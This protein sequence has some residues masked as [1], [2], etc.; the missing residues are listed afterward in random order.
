[1]RLSRRPSRQR[2]E[3]RSHYSP[4]RS[5]LVSVGE[6]LE[7]RILLFRNVLNFGDGIHEAITSQALQFLRE[8]VLAEINLRHQVQDTAGAANSAN[9]FDGSEFEASAAKINEYLSAAIAEADPEDFD[10][11]DLEEQWGDML[12]TVQDFYAHSNWV[13]LGMSSLIDSG[14]GAWNAM[15]PYSLHSGAMLVEG[16]D[17]T[18]TVPGFGT[19]TLRR[20]AGVG[21]V[22]AGGFQGF[23]IVVDFGGG[24]TFPGVISGTFGPDNSPDNVSIGHDDPTFGTDRGLNKDSTSRHLH[25][26]A[27]VLAV[28]QTRHEFARLGALLEAEYG[29]EAVCKLLEVWVK[30]DEVSQAEA[31]ALLGI[32]HGPLD[33]VFVIDT[34]GSMGDDIAAVKASANEII[35]AIAEE[36]PC[37]RVSIVLYK[38]SGDTYVTKTWLGFTDDKD[39][40]LAA[41][42]SI[43]VGGGGDFPEAV[44]AA[45]DHAIL[46]LDGMGEWR[47]PSVEKS[48]ILMGDAP[49][50]DPDVATG[51]TLASVT[52]NALRAGLFPVSLAGASGLATGNLTPPAGDPVDIFTIVIGSNTAATEAFQ[53]IAAANRGRMF[54]AATA[55]DVVDAVLDAI[56]EVTGDS[57]ITGQKWNDLDGD[58]LRDA[59]EPGLD[60]WIVNVIDASGDIVGS[61][62]TAS[63]DLD[64]NGIIDPF[65]ESGI[66]TVAVSAGSYTVVEVVSSGWVQTAPSSPVDVVANELDEDFDF[67]TTGN[68]FRDWGGL[69][70]RWIYSD[71]GWHYITPAGG[72]FRWWGGHGENLNSSLVARLSPDYHAD[73]DLLASAPAPVEHVV[74][75]ASGEVVTGIDFGNR[76][77]STIGGQKWEDVNRDGDRDSGDRALN[78]WV[79]ELLDGTSGDV[80]AATTTQSLDLNLDGRIDPDTEVG[81]YLFEGVVPGT[82]D[83]REVMK[84][85]WVASTP[86]TDLLQQATD[87]DA[88]RDF[89]D[90]AATFPNWGGLNEKWIQGADGW[91]FI[92]PDGQVKKW[93]NSPRTAL[94]GTLVA[95]LSPW[96]HA[97]THRLTSPVDPASNLIDISTTTEISDRDFGNYRT[98]GTAGLLVSGNSGPGLVPGNVT[99]TQGKTELTIKGDRYDNQVAVFVNWE[100]NLTVV[101]LQGTK[102]NGRSEPLILR[103][104]T[105]YLSGKLKADMGDGRDLVALQGFTI[106]GDT[107]IEGGHG[108]DAFVS[109]D[110][111]FGRNLDILGGWGAI[112]VSLTDTTIANNLSVNGSEAIDTVS[113]NQVT[114]SNFTHLDMG[115]KSDLLLVRNSDFHDDARIR[116]GS[117]DDRL[118]GSGRAD[119]R[120]LLSVDGNPG[121]DSWNAASFLYGRRSTSSMESFVLADIDQVIDDVLTAFAVYGLDESLIK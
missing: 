45:L 69:D 93:N 107:R 105:T 20:V 85:G 53:A 71:A 6:S 66:Y 49:P 111:N 9:H 87:L 67:R 95:T 121:K 17:E 5:S 90:S 63:V 75:V 65:T 118:A 97:Q 61:A 115:A 14:T 110:M 43:S 80:I 76:G 98:N 54:T 30:P 10:Q 82:Y 40:A 36:S 62:T 35:N 116:L 120:R 25:D 86:S 31:A 21:D 27:R 48:I 94:T 41:I 56:G 37:F 119:F 102:V 28:Q 23:G 74:T 96:F 44:F 117:G 22:L 106:S 89:R 55:D 33:L 84:P 38:D 1:M 73:L 108:A 64:G 59:D 7:H 34:T 16:E 26:E 70:E 58:G 109:I 81:V 39:A 68:D 112:D 103:T 47:G 101:G 42:S 72:L 114:V 24:V 52:E 15:T 3:M 83:V 104:G 32:D 79:I 92:T 57:S 77:A 2:R 4:E 12:H 46:N 19:A 13:N 11:E 29:H 51:A 99:V 60:G 50:H 100:G 8:E 88:A 18:P 91:Y 113:L 78:G